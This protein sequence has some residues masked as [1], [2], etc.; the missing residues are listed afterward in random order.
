VD[1]TGSG[2]RPMAGFGNRN[3]ETFGS[4]ARDLVH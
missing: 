4:A 3:V 2:S 1:G